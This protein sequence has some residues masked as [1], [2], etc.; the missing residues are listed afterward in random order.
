MAAIRTTIFDSPQKAA[1]AMVRAKA[2][3]E[4]GGMPAGLLMPPIRK[5]PSKAVTRPIICRASS[6][7]LK[8]KAAKKIVKKAWVWRRI[9]ESPAGMPMYMA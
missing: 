8:K 5:R 7:S 4:T 6:F 1:A 2:V 9:E 3:K